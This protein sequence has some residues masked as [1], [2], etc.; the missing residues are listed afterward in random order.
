MKECVKKEDG[1][2]QFTMTIQSVP[3]PHSVKWNIKENNTDTFEPINVSAAEYIGTSN[4]FPH[5]VLVIK[6]K[7]KLDNCIFEIEV[8]NRIGEVKWMISGNTDFFKYT[9]H[10]CLQFYCTAS[11]ILLL[12]YRIKNRQFS[13]RY[14]F[15]TVIIICII[16]GAQTTI[17]KQTH[18][19][20][21]FSQNL[22]S[23][24]HKSWN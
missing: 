4:T 23:N 17:Q 24:A 5:P 20:I 12:L 2:L 19:K 16:L 11:A 8:K 6:H 21:C 9:F 10:N 15:A 13:G 22:L 14:V 3:V 7:E 18:K 1:S